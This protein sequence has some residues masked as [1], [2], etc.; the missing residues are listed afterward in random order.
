V[1]ASNDAASFA[2]EHYMNAGS[3]RVGISETN[4]AKSQKRSN[5]EQKKPKQKKDESGVAKAG[6]NKDA[7]LSIGSNRK[8]GQK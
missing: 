2:Q 4:M 3:T 7:P 5:R 1:I 6:A 8:L